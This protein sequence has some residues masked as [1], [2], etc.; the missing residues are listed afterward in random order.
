MLAR[1]EGPPETQW[2]F[3]TFDG[4]LQYSIPEIKKRI[5]DW[6]Y[7]KMNGVVQTG[8]FR[9]MKLGVDESW[10]DGAL[11]NKI[12][13]CY[14]EELHQPLEYEIKR[15]EKL[16]NPKIVNVGCAEGYYA[17]GMACRLPK[18]SVWVIDTDEALEIAGEAARANGRNITASD[19][20]HTFQN[21]DLVICDCEGAE[22]EYLDLEKFPDLARSTIIVECHEYEIQD[23]VQILADRFGPT[24]DLMQAVCGARDPG[25]YEFLRPW[26]QTLQWLA[27][28]EARPA[29]MRWLI[30]RPPTNA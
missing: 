17:V 13:G 1:L 23:T 30:M 2:P 20:Y 9:G 22:V 10:K 25:K 29:T 27:M 6:L 26:H 5:N 15:L 8:P 16:D 7:D 14:E 11:G 28:D 3:E 4:H 21:P 19:L 18:A 24:H 12:I